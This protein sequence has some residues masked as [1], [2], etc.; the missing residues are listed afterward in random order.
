DRAARAG[1]APD[2][3]ARRV[4]VAAF[5]ASIRA[6]IGDDAR[7]IPIAL[8]TSLPSS[9]RAAVPAPER[10]GGRRGGRWPATVPAPLGALIVLVVAIA[11]LAA[12]ASSPL[13]TGSSGADTGRA[14]PAPASVRPAVTRE[15]APSANPP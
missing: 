14:T 8:P 12:A 6:A 5:A 10:S 1:L 7:T 11:A 2:P 13:L 3:A 4:D 9:P 15:P